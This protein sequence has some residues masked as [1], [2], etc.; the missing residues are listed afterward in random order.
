[1]TYDEEKQY[2]YLIFSITIRCQDTLKNDNY[3][4]VVPILG[5]TNILVCKNRI[6]N[7]KCK[8]ALKNAI[9]EEV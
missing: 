2:V 1:M 6:L 9:L 3:T 7:Y 8:N 5:R 4:V